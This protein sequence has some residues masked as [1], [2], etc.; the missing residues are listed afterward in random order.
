MKIQKIIA[1]LM[2]TSFISA[3]A[4]ADCDFSKGIQP[5]PNKTFIYSEACHLTVG[6]LVEQNKTY[7][8]Q[9][10]DL[11]KALALDTQA[12]AD[13]NK[14]LDDS[15]K[16]VV[17]W[18]TTSLKMEDSLQKYDSLRSQNQWLWFLLGVLVTS[19]AGITAAQLSHR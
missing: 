15:D 18:Q 19:A 6:T 13:K 5:G 8:L 16:R 9:L 7:G 10:V 12:I 1:S 4:L 3:Q 2:L 11:N 17:L 14:A